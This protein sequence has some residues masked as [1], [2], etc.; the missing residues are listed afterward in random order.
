[1]EK[2]PGDPRYPIFGTEYIF[3]G[4]SSEEL[5]N[6]ILKLTEKYAPAFRCWNGSLPEIVTMKPEHFEMIMSSSNH[7]TKGQNYNNFHDWL[8]QGLLTSSGN[9]WFRHRKLITPTFHFKILENYMNVFVAKTEILLNIL[10]RKADGAVHNIYSEITHCTLDIICE[11][12]MGVNINAMFN[13]DNEYVKCVYE[14]SDIIFWKSLR[15]YIPLFIFNLFPS[16]RKLKKNLKILHGFS[17][18]VISDRKKLLKDK[19]DNKSHNNVIEEEVLGLRK[20]LSFLDLLIEASEDG[21][22]LNDIDIRQEVDTFMFE[23]HDTTSAS[24]SW[25][26]LLLGNHPD[27]QER[28]FEEVRNVLHDKLTPTSINELNEFK[29]LERVIKE[30]LRLYPSVPAIIRHTKEEIQIDEYKIPPNVDVVLLIYCVHRDPK[31]YPNPEKFDPDRFLPE[32]CVNR[33]PYAYVP[34]SAGSRNCV[35]QKFALYEEK[36]ILAS[37]INRYKVTAAKRMEDIQAN[38]DLILRPKRGVLLAF[39]RRS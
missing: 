15:P 12:A 31:V 39:E 3:I 18:K 8:G 27:I 14:I 33:H 19:Q 25:T 38:V 4:A 20:R 35:G 7:I 36:T 13:D 30:S 26:L 22:V 16:G 37:I 23:G 28:V 2:L 9:R 5:F 21:K 29:Y 11:S 17:E 6:I 10:D 34:F 1:M 24:L 32:N